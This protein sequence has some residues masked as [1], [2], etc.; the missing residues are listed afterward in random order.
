MQWSLLVDK[1]KTIGCWQYPVLMACFSSRGRCNL[2]VQYSNGLFIQIGNPALSDKRLS[3]SGVLSTC[4]AGFELFALSQFPLPKP[5]KRPWKCYL[6]K[7]FLPMNYH[8]PQA[9]SHIM[10]LDHRGTLTSEAV[11]SIGKKRNSRSRVGRD[12][13]IQKLQVWRKNM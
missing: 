12:S 10:P 11:E 7:T 2:I 8:S 4:F 9:T 3:P 1:C 6:M 5:P 13:S